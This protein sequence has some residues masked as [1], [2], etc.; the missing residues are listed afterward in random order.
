MW[1]LWWFSSKIK[2]YPSSNQNSYTTY[3]LKTKQSEEFHPQ[4]QKV[5]FKS[6][7]TQY[8]LPQGYPN[9]VSKEYLSFV[10]WNQV[11]FLSTNIL[12]FIST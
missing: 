1:S 7:L 5:Q 6:L 10:T 12:S 8:L 4:E 3:D 11:S 2:I 9:S